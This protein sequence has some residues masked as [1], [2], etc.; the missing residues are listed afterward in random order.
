[1]VQLTQDCFAFGKKLIKLETALNKIKK[2][3]KPSKTI[4]EINTSKS[5]NRIIANDI[6]A[7]NNIPP[8]SNSAV[9][10]Y[11]I[12]YKQYKSGNRKFSIAGKS[13]AGHPYKQKTKKLATIKILTGAILPIGYDTVI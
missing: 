8:H 4:E 1:M 5:L 12:K 7:R 6:I 11:A 9:D 10:G 13:T 2:N 3:I